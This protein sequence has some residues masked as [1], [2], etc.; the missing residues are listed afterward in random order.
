ME[1]L[2]GQCKRHSQLVGDYN[3]IN[4]L[5]NPMIDLCRRPIGKYPSGMA[6]AHCQVDHDD[7]KRFFV[8]ADGEV[9]I[10]P[11]IISKIGTTKHK[12]GCLSYPFRDMKFVNRSIVVTVW[13]RNSKWEEVTKELEGIKAYIFQHEIDHFNGKHIYS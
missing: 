10:N 1:I 2:Q 5:I 12:E 9:V 11:K 3:E 6:L 7:P 8:F 4:H 13:Y